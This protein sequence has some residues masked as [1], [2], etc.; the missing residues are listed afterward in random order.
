MISNDEGKFYY[1]LVRDL[2]KLVAGRT[3]Y[4]GFTHVY[5]YCL[6]C[7]Y[8]ATTYSRHI[9]RNV[10]SIPSRRLFI[11]SGDILHD[12]DVIVTFQIMETDGDHIGRFCYYIIRCVEVGV[13]TV[14][15]LGL[16]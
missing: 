7:L 15:I 4:R 9:C 12:D 8:C 5:P 14:H 13:V 2:S 10:R 3:N 16:L 6:Y 1:L 11:F